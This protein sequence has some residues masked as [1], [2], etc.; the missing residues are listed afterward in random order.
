MWMW[1]MDGVGRMELLVWNRS[2]KR[3]RRG[4]VNWF[5]SPFRYHLLDHIGD[6]DIT[7]EAWQGIHSSYRRH[8]TYLARADPSCILFLLV[9]LFHALEHAASVLEELVSHGRVIEGGGKGSE[10]E[11]GEGA[12]ERRRGL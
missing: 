6:Q 9:S 5:L 1:R 8:W 12:K 3:A 7:H 4:S 2:T 10:D 11:R